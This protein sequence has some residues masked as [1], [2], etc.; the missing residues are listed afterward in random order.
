M[1]LSRFPLKLEVNSKPLKGPII[2]PIRTYYSK[3]PLELLFPTTDRRFYFL[4]SYVF[5]SANSVPL[6]LLLLTSAL[7]FN[8]YI[9]LFDFQL[10][11]KSK[12]LAYKR[13]ARCVAGLLKS[14]E[15]YPES[16][17]TAMI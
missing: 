6:Y 1:R 7:H 8:S 12:L 5:C 16:T 10:I 4:K 2:C 9:L 13:R 14:M 15:R 3:V 17:V 11:P